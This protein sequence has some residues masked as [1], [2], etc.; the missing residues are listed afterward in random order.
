VVRTPWVVVSD[1]GLL[2]VHLD[3]IGRADLCQAA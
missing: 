3:A 1:I 2:S